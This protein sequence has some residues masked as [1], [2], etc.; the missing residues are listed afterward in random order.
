MKKI[1]IIAAVF[2]FYAFLHANTSRDLGTEPDLN[3]KLVSKWIIFYTNIER[4]TNGQAP[5]QYDPELEKA[6]L[7]QAEYC[8]KIK[9][10]DHTAR[11]KNMA[12]H[13]DRIEFFGGK[14]GNCGENLTVKFS[15]NFEGIPVS[16]KNDS[17]GVYYDYGSKTVYWLTEQQ[18]AFIMIDGWM[19]SPGHRKNILRP[20]FLWIGAGSVKGVYNNFSSYYGC[21]VFNGYGGLPPEHFKSKY[22]LSG[23]IAK[24]K[25]SNGKEIFEISYDGTFIPGIVEI[26][27]DAELITHPLEKNGAQYTFIKIPNIKGQLFAALYDK[28]Q[29]M[30]YPVI[31]LK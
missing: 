16:V 12:K 13:K 19:K 24:K 8:S 3:I 1:I 14:C 18:M 2:V 26:N 5:L 10:L 6:A 17:K 9:T 21:Q 7:W 4:L 30:L 29:D 22:E 20:G 25:I 28:N 23:I 11:V 27:G 31:L 15:A